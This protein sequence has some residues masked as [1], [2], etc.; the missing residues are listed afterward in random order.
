MISCLGNGVT[1]TRM[2][3]YPFCYRKNCK[4]CK[5]A[6]KHKIDVTRYF[7]TVYD[8]VPKNLIPLIYIY[9]Y[10]SLVER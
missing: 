9:S 3:C 10:I 2:F 7:T 1:E 6:L 8:V 5:I 4:I